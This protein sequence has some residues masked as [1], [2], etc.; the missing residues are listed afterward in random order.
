[1]TATVRAWHDEEGWGVLD[2]SE[3]ARRSPQ[4]WTGR[5]RLR[6]HRL[7]VAPQTAAVCSRTAARASLVSIMPLRTRTT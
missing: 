7:R 1:M 2:S 3:H 6:L 5:L 4:Q